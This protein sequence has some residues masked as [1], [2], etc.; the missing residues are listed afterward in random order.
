MS[1][2]EA[3]R[4]LLDQRDQSV[5][6]QAA[7]LDLP[8]SRAA[9]RYHASEEY[10]ALKRLLPGKPGR[11]L[12]L[13]AGNGILAYALAADGWKVTAVEPDPSELVGAGAIRAL[14][15]ET[16]VAIEV[17][18]AFGEAV[19][20]DAAG[21]DVVVARQVL[22]HAND[23]GQFCREM[24]R[25]A[26]PGGLVV[27]L[28]DHVISGP[29]QMQAFLD[30]HPLHHLYGG[31]NAFTLDA[32]RSAL[33]GAGLVVER[34][35]GSFDSVINYA[36]F[37]EADIRAAAAASLPGFIRPLGAAAIALAPFSLLRSLAS[38]V[39]RRPGRLVSFVAKKPGG[40][41]A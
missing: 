29:Q 6:A 16:G 10:Q 23:L 17:V 28:R 26:R 37:T 15:K 31:E 9:Q 11:A 33:S 2:E 35:L 40:S 36:P 27:T 7:Y 14:S 32:Y 18:E 8:L 20:M 1:W 24:A 12:D 21:Y 22:H 41:A 38:A 5:L 3:V 25:L 19:P 4:W 13:G 30:G 39:D 34:A